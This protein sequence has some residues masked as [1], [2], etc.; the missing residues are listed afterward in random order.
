MSASGRV[1]ALADVEDMTVA[2]PSAQ[3]VGLDRL[4]AALTRDWPIA[5]GGAE[6]I[7]AAMT[8]FALLP[9]QC[10]ARCGLEVRCHDGDRIDGLVMA[11]S[12]TELQSLT[13]WIAETQPGST[14][15]L[16][17]SASTDFGWL[18]IDTDG[19]A[20][21]SLGWFTALPESGPSPL[22][23]LVDSTAAVERVIGALRGAQALQLGF[24]PSRH[25][26]AVRLFA[27]CDEPS[28]GMAA[29]TSVDWPGSKQAAA[30][31]LNMGGGADVVRVN[32]DIVDGEL[33]PTVGWEFSFY[34][35]A[36][37]VIE[38]R[39]KALFS[40]LIDARLATPER[41]AALLAWPTLRPLSR[42]TGEWLERGIA[43]VKV[44]LDP[45]GRIEAKA[46]VGGYSMVPADA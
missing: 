4:S 33:F 38:P 13:T 28:S 16:L 27:V 22:S 15:S 23:D 1:R 19:S 35:D 26:K 34:D 7:A 10:A 31:L 20:V 6:A 5:L 30:D 39:W 12:G 9:T 3:P 29:L 42:L 14:L 24:F 46:Y 36:Q 8:G 21:A 17:A 40:R 37:P 41:A 25:P 32:L 18:E 44:S 11:R 43:H 45:S 2:R